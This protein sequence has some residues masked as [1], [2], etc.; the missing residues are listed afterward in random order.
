MANV[1]TTQKVGQILVGLVLLIV[2]AACADDT[3]ATDQNPSTTTP[4]T[5]TTD[6][7]TTSTTTTLQTQAPQTTAPPS[8]TTTPAEPA[9]IGW[10]DLENLSFELDGDTVGL[11][12]GQATISYDGDSETM[13]LLQNR[14]TQGDLD[15]DGDDDLVAHIIERS[16][17]TGVFHLIVPVINSEGTPQPQTPVHVGD[18]VIIEEIAVE[19]GLI[20]VTLLDRLDDEPFTVITQRKTLKIDLTGAEPQAQVISTKPLKNLPLPELD[21]PDIA[22]QF[23]AGETSATETGTIEPN[24]R[25]TYTLQASEQ[26]AIN[27]ELTAPLGVW[28]T[29][30]FGYFVLAPLDDRTQTINVILPASGP[31]RLGVVSTHGEAAD[32]EMTATVLPLGA[33]TDPNLVVPLPTIPIRPT[34]EPGDVVY[35]TIDDG[36][37][38]VYTPQMLDVLARHNARATFFVVGYLVERYPAIVERIV[39]EGHTVANHTWLHEDLTT[40]SRESFDQ[41]ISRTQEILGEHATPCLRPPYGSRDAFT[42]DWAASHGLAIALWTVDTFDWRNPGAETIA[43]RIVAGASDGAIVSLHD[44]GGERSQTVQALDDALTRLADSGI[45]YE[46]L[47]Q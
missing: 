8:T 38:P 47:C 30:D 43:N 22:I 32:Y 23:E 7:T 10:E 36:P 35:L 41:T 6:T 17:G 24:Q 11:E 5:D 13:F 16:A 9:L 21:L 19:H 4:S 15:N 29:V 20:E 31:W 18:R 45:R 40:L 28:L 25:Q 37:H 12:D 46:P 2:T 26:Q 14:V 27:V 39:A 1:A 33:F 34:A 42:Y 44:G 3:T